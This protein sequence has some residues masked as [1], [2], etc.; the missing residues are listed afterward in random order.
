VVRA[1]RAAA[2]IHHEKFPSAV[3][4][5][6]DLFS[7]VG[8]RRPCRETD[9]CRRE[10]RPLPPSGDRRRRATS[11]RDRRRREEGCQAGRI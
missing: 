11:S 7:L 4:T 8:P 2:R 5:S 3:K 1:N 6:A 9:D 10:A